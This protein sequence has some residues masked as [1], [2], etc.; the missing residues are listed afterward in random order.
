MRANADIRCERIMKS[1]GYSYEKAQSFMKN[2]PGDE[3]YLE[4]A[5]LVID[6]SDDENPE[7][8]GDQLKS[9]LENFLSKYG[10]RG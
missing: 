7:S 3:Y 4:H 6:N 10:F 2:Q 5:D 1:R 9:V 8:L